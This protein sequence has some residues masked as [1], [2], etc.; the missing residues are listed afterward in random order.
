MKL[1]EWFISGTRLLPHADSYH[2]HVFNHVLLGEREH[3][4]ILLMIC[5]TTQST[6]VSLTNT[7]ACPLPEAAKPVSQVLDKKI[8]LRI[9]IFYL[10]IPQILLFRIR[11]FFYLPRSV[12]SGKS[13]YS[14]IKLVE[15]NSW[16]TERSFKN[17]RFEFCVSTTTYEI[18]E[19]EERHLRGRE[20]F[21]TLFKRS[22][23]NALWGKT[24]EW[25]FKTH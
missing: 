22:F 11:F 10:C 15:R 7:E 4:N 12:T 20:F 19:V 16:R 5:R 8:Y 25:Y 23:K 13:T 14:L 21:Y 17:W 6:G 2:F 3:R 24:Y 1:H 9:M 18:K